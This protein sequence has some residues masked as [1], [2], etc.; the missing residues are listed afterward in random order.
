VHD[1]PDLDDAQKHDRQQ[2][3][4]QDE[5]DNGGA[6]LAAVPPAAVPSVPCPDQGETLL[7]AVRKT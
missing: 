6:A 3:R 7:I 5:L 1:D 4:D 2:P